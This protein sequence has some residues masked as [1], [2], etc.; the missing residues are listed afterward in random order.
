M[1]YSFFI[2]PLSL[3]WFLF[4]FSLCLGALKATILRWTKRDS[5]RGEWENN[6]CRLNQRLSFSYSLVNLFVLFHCFIHSLFLCFFYF[7]F[8]FC[9]WVQSKTKWRYFTSQFTNVLPS[10]NLVSLIRWG[11]NREKKK[12]FNLN[13]KMFCFVFSNLFSITVFNFFHFLYFYYNSVLGERVNFNQNLKY[14]N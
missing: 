4:Y 7:F 6:I 13:Q 12:M 11:R 5:G 10:E 14:K 9:E 3:Y 8:L 1:L 2:S